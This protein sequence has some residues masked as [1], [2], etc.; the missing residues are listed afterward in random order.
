MPRIFEPRNI[1]HDSK[2]IHPRWLRRFPR[3][4][5]YRQPRRGKPASLQVLQ[6]VIARA[7]AQRG[8]QKLRRRHAG[9]LSAILHRLVAQNRVSPRFGFEPDPIQE[10]HYGF[11]TQ[12]GASTA[13]LVQDF[14]HLFEHLGGRIRFGKDFEP[15]QFLPIL[16]PL[17]VKTAA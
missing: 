16:E 6:C 17:I 5:F 11:H 3:F 4:D 14:L 12:P 2:V 1:D 15:L 7:S 8:Q 9:I 13:R 10:P